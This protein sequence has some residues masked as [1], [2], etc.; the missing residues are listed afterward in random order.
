MTTAK[1]IGLLLLIGG[2]T[3]LAIH[4]IST[5]EGT[6]TGTS[7]DIEW[8]P[9]GRKY[10]DPIPFTKAADCKECHPDV[11]AEWYGSHHRIA[12]TNPE[13][14]KLS[15]GFQGKGI[16]CLPCH[17]AGPMFGTGFGVRPLE[18]GTNREDGVD[19]FTCHFW[20]EGNAMLTAGPLGGTASKAPCQ[21]AVTPSM[22][23]LK[24]CAP[25]HDQHKVHKDW[26][27]TRFAIPGDG[28]KDCNDCHMPEVERRNAAGGLRKGRSHRFPAAHDKDM[29][30]SAA[31]V[32][33]SLSERTLFVT[34]HNSGTGHNLPSDERHRAVDLH[35]VLDM[36]DGRA[37]DVR[38]ERWRN[39]YRDEFEATNPLPNPG[40]EYEKTETV[41]EL[42][43]DVGVH[44]KRVPA[45]HHPQ[46]TVW[47]PAS[48]QI[49]AGEKRELTI[50][51]PDGFKKVT[52]RLWYRTNPFQLDKDAVLLHEKTLP[53]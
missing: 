23:S 35:L 9:P 26:K 33:Q 17:L 41:P 21:P 20:P 32:T 10:R 46:R 1:L 14:Q 49:P 47:Y 52:L 44:V 7:R 24:L 12:Y 39:P 48:T 38:I 22:R 6:T 8:E 40:D 19:C 36:G 5:P 29:L 3:F 16:D 53:E 45:A 37:Y 18:R 11:W 34:V 28:F 25:C 15:F 51:L 2:A 27:E 43:A 50:E 30:R 31:T 42:L 4:V 13:V